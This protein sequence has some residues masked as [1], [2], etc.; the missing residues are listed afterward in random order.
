MMKRLITVLA[1][2]ALSCGVVLAQVPG[3][4]PANSIW[5]NP[6]AARALP[7][8]I[9]IPSCS[10]AT[11]ALTWTA[12]SG[13]GCNNISATGVVSTGAVGNVGV[14]TATTTIGPNTSFNFSGS[15]LSLGV[16]NTTV[17]N[18][19]L[20]NATSGSINLHAPTGAL[21]SAD[22]TL[23]IGTDT[24][25][26]NASTATLT[27]KT[28][29]T[30]GAGNSFSI[31]GLAA[32]AN[33]GTGAVVR[34]TGPTLGAI[35]V[36]SVNKLTFTQPAT[37]ATLTLIDGK[38]LTASNS[39]QLIGTDGTS[40]SGPSTNATLAA[41]NIAS[42]TVTGGANVTTL[43]NSTGNLAVDCGARQLQS[44]SNAA[45]FT[46]TAPANDGACIVMVTN[47]AGAGAITAAAAQNFSVPTTCPATGCGDA[48][49]NTVGNVFS[50]HIWR[51]G[52]VAGY[53]IAAHQ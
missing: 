16:A 30:A 4:F 22:L 43:A 1:A 39:I 29:D 27:N 6:T 31:N 19:K 40:W 24:L 11:N 33:T 28:F 26:A 53:R 36:T 35:T 42:Q 13:F 21:G 23:P 45:A 10:G 38:T 3:Q 8:T 52:G 46:I 14:Y 17:G 18:L 51:I 34:V 50:W 25:T 47:A 9:A 5:G 2:L 48:P 32:N 12:A 37:G 49:T 20:F 44:I 7:K 15:T 41:L